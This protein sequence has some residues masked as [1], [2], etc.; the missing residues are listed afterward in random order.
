[1]AKRINKRFLRTLTITVVVV[2]GLAGAA[3]VIARQWWRDPE[4]PKKDGNWYVSLYQ[5]NYVPEYLRGTWELDLSVNRPSGNPADE[6]LAPEKLLEKAAIAYGRAARYARTDP[7]IAVVIGDLRRL[8]TRYDPKMIGLDV[9]AWEGAL[10]IDSSYR[11]AHERLLNAAIEGMEVSPSAAG[12]DRLGEKAQK[13]AGIDSANVRAQAYCDIAVIGGW[14]MGKATA[15]SAV[16]ERVDSLMKL[17]QKDPRLADIPQFIAKASLRLARDRAAAGDRVRAR[18]LVMRAMDAFDKASKG[19]EENPQFGYEQYRVL[20][21]IADSYV[22][23]LAS[24]EQGGPTTQGVPSTQPEQ[25]KAARELQQ[26]ARAALRQ[27][28]ERIRGNLGTK[29][30]YLRA[31]A[32][33][34]RAWVASV[35]RD[36]ADSKEKAEA[37]AV[38]EDLQAKRRFDQAVR[39]LAARVRSGEGD[40]EKAEELLREPA[41]SNPDLLGYRAAIKPRLEIQRVMDLADLRLQMYDKA[42]SDPAVS[43]DT[44]KAKRV[45]I[46]EGYEWAA[47]RLLAEDWHLL[48]LKGKMLLTLDGDLRAI[49]EAIA[50]LQKAYDKLESLRQMDPEL[51]LMLSHAYQAVQQDEPAKAILSRMVR[52][53]GSVSVAK[54][55]IPLLLRDKE[56]KQAAPYVAVLEQQLPND[57]EVME[58]CLVLTGAEEQQLAGP[59]PTGVNPR[60]V[61]KAKAELSA[62][63]KAILERVR[64]LPEDKREQRLTK[65]RLMLVSKDAASAEKLLVPLSEEELKNA[66]EKSFLASRLLIGTYVMQEKKPA[67]QQLADRVV[68]KVPQSAEWKLMAAQLRG[69]LTAE[70]QRKLNEELIGQAKDEGEKAIGQYSLLMTE[71]AKNA[72]KGLALLQEAEK[73]TPQHG[74]LL[75]TIW[76][77][78]VNSKQWDLAEKYTQKLAEINWD[79]AQGFTYKARV[80]LARNDVEG[81][82]RD[83]ME[84]SRQAPYFASTWVLLGDAQREAR[85]LESAIASYGKAIDRQSDNSQALLGL[86]DCH[87]GLGQVERAK[88][89]IQRGMQFTR[90][91]ELF[92]EKARRVDEA[93]D[94]LEVVKSATAQREKELEKDRGNVGRWMVLAEDYRRVAGITR[95][96]DAEKSQQYVQKATKLMEEAVAKFP[97]ELGVYQLLA[98]LSLLNEKPERGL[99]LLNQLKAREAWKNKPEPCMLLA[100]YLERLG[101]DAIAPAEQAW[102]EALSKAK[103]SPQIQG[104]IVE[105]YIRTGQLEKAVVGLTRIAQETKD[106]GARKRLVELYLSVRRFAEAEKL[107]GEM[108]KESPSD[109]ALLS[110]LGSLKIEQGDY[111]AAEESLMQARKLDPNYL[112]VR[113]WLGVMKIHRGDLNDAIV[114]L[115][116]ACDLVPTNAKLRMTLADA[117]ARSNQLEEATRE[118]EAALRANPLH[119]QLR[120]RLVQY[121]LQ[122]QRWIPAQRVLDEAKSN[123]ELGDDPIWSRIESSMWV[124]RGNLQQAYN[125]LLPATTLAPGDPAILQ[126]LWDL[127]LKAQGYDE[128]IEFSDK[129]I[130]MLQAEI[131]RRQEAGEQATLNLPWWMHMQRGMARKGQG[132]LDLAMQEFESGLSAVDRVEDDAAAEAMVS[133]MVEAVGYEKTV[134][135]LSARAKLRWKIALAR[136]YSAQGDWNKAIKAL[137]ELLGQDYANLSDRQK[138]MALRTAG[139]AYHAASASVPGAAAKAE[140]AYYR[141]LKEM[142]DR[143]LDAEAQLDTLNNLALFL[144]ER[145]GAADPEKARA[146][147]TQ[148]YEIMRKANAFNPGVVDT[149]GWVLV[150]SGQVDAGIELLRSAASKG[151]P[152]AWY[153]LGEAYAKK[154]DAKAAWSSLVNASDLLKKMKANKQAVEPALEA[155]IDA[156][157]KRVAPTTQPSR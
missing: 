76:N 22:D 10:E 122:N 21:G 63:R 86:V 14:L 19:A 103:D 52:S 64:A 130:Q 77:H 39:L 105:F 93:S 5:Q 30:N 114:E 87:L 128:V 152:D 3:A 41:E 40:L 17:Q 55:L 61:E 15:E 78:A 89:Y 46:E 94:N 24:T 140:Q 70:E 133:A 84:A 53:S 139:P 43:A 125:T 36:P 23:L 109:V 27:S 112:D 131:K 37:K 45:Q 111:K 65:A 150:L 20:D 119:R 67:A 9:A 8:M 137:D 4:G 80:K 1:M 99:A 157:M 118:L 32:D 69:N 59:M 13:L 6:K 85:D 117:Y 129:K 56:Y 143:R 102:M 62:K 123:P 151:N 127:L 42:K 88:E 116:A 18:A 34:L 155:R 38:L 101:Q 149:H 11:L 51:S 97:D 146:Y 113:Y 156:A 90:Q 12:F 92:A 135:A 82:L 100:E 148:A 147:S 35:M 96:S 126:Q 106:A 81:A 144:A 31:D 25:I 134:Q 33:I 98:N 71:D 79:Q 110:L 60:A 91:S 75:E 145:P 16:E 49:R 47:N 138:L 95:K 48:K 2:V 141:C 28:A 104:A 142:E 29:G 153:H 136:A 124:M 26:R 120:I 154:G 74:R 108:L 58:Y 44:L 132:K 83:A 73:K 121:Y 50:P 54:R 68:G 72:E 57:P 115:Q 66:D 7:K 107:L